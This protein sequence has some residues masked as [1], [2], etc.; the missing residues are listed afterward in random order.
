MPRSPSLP[1]LKFV[2]VG[3]KDAGK[4]TFV[5]CALDLK[6]P[7][8]SHIAS[9]K[10]S[11]EGD[12]FLISLIE[13][14]LQDVDVAENAILWPHWVQQAGVSHVDGVLALYDVT[15]RDTLSGIPGLLS[16]S[17]VIRY[18]H[19]DIIPL[20]CLQHTGLQHCLDHDRRY[21][22]KSRLILWRRCMFENRHSMCFSV[23]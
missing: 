15:E 11:L 16:M 23:L 13:I 2:V 4:S 18:C 20:S 19:E 1:E 14:Q 6:R 12:V 21:S 5:R 8:S 10:M 7:P 17:P 3:A 22:R 9:K